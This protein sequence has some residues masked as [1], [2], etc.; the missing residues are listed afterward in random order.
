VN[1]EFIDNFNQEVIDAINEKEIFGRNEKPHIKH[2]ENR[3]DLIG[4]LCED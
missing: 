4:T 1:S 2:I 3:L